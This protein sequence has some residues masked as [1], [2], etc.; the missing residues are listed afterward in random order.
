MNGG[1]NVKK[2]MAWFCLFC[3]MCCW[4]II[5]LS[6]SADDENL[7]IFEENALWGVMDES[8]EIIVAPIY[9]EIAGFSNGYSCVYT[10]SGEGLIDSCGKLLAPC[11]F[12]SVT[13][14]EDG[15]Y[16][17]SHEE[18]NS[19]IYEFYSIDGIATGWRF[20]FAYGFHNGYACV[21][22][23][24]DEYLLDIE[25]NL[26]SIAP[27]HLAWGDGFSEERLLVEKDGL[28]GYLD[29]SLQLVIPCIYTWADADF[30]DGVAEVE[31][32]I[33]RL[34]IDKYGS[35]VE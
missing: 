12:D 3:V 4:W 22:S 20:E 6:E 35:I 28:Y 13:I 29:S 30:L 32:N 31:N 15:F 2:K 8:G 18:E 11:I 10:E 5:S 26:H 19:T 17:V 27:Y 24:G 14:P 21:I 1:E 9:T 23:N 16:V 33:E 7:I 25:G 34:Y